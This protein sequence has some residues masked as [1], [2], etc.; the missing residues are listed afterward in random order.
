MKVALQVLTVLLIS[1]YYCKLECI[2]D[3]FVDEENNATS[4]IL[5]TP[6][7]VDVHSDSIKAVASFFSLEWNKNN[8]DSNNFFRVSCIKRGTSQIVSGVAYNITVLLS[9]TTCK[10]DQFAEVNVTQLSEGYLM[11]ECPY[12]NNELECWFKL[13]NKPWLNKLVL[14]DYNCFFSS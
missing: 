7:R 5:G 6:V 1:V 8:T 13:I 14:L 11:D 4:K 2:V 9:E 10:K 3:E 12:T